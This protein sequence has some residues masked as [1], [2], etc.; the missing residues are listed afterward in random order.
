MFIIDLITNY[1]I[2]ITSFN[3]HLYAFLAISIGILVVIALLQALIAKFAI[4]NSSSMLGFSLVYAVSMAVVA[5]GFVYIIN[6][7]TS[8]FH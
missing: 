8:L 3:A 2:L 6:F 7:V 4:K 1:K 5:F